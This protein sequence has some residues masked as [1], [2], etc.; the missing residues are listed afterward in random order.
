M[1]KLFTALLLATVTLVAIAQA[2]QR[3]KVILL[4]AADVEE[5]KRLSAELEAAQ[6]RFA[7]YQERI[8]GKYISVEGRCSDFVIIGQ[9]LPDSAYKPCRTRKEGWYGG[10]EFSED[11]KAI[12]P[13]AASEPGIRLGGGFCGWSPVTS[14]GGGAYFTTQ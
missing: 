4:D 6:K 2:P 14:L 7:D 10:F 3:A 11:F 8:E 5:G 12:V 1:R 9:K 13:K